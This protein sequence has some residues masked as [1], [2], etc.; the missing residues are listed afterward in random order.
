MVR[1][2]AGAPP[3]D[4]KLGQHMRNDPSQPEEVSGLSKIE[5]EDLLDR[6]E[7]VGYEPC[8]LSFVDGQGFCVRPSV[9]PTEDEADLVQSEIGRTSLESNSGSLS[10]KP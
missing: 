9:A 2:Q 7:A 8:Q 6:L 4:A 1:E 5:A 3:W 10:G